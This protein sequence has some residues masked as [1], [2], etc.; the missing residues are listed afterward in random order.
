MLGSITVITLGLSAYGWFRRRKL[1]E[2]EQ[3]YLRFRF[4]FGWKQS[5]SIDKIL[6]VCLAVVLLGA[7]F[8]SIFVY[9]KNQQGFTSIFAGEDGSPDFLKIFGGGKANSALQ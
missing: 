5:A 3:I 9:Q 8:T 7:V 4:N 1:P 6:V 2:E